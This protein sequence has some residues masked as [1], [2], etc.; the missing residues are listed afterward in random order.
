M[1]PKSRQDFTVAIICALS[2]EADAVEA[3]FD[4]TYDRLGKYYGK[5]QGDANA[6]IN[7][8]I[9]NHDVVLCYTSGIGKGSAASVA[10]SLQVSYTGIEL[11]LV[12]G[13][14]GGTSS[15]S[16]HQEIFLGDAIISDSV[17]VYDFGRQYPGGF[18]RKSG[19]KDTLGRPN[20][21][22]R[23]LLNG[24][25]TN[26]AL[27]EL[28]SQMQGYLE[29][30]QQKGTRWRHPQIDD[31]LFKASYLHKHY[32]RASDIQCGCSES[33]IP[34]EIC[35]SA[36]EESC[37]DLGCDKGQIIRCREFGEATKASI[38]IGILASA[39]IVMKSGQHRDAIVRKEKIIGFEMEGAGVWDNISCIIIKG[40]CD[41]ADSHKN[42]LWQDY[43]AATG[44]SAAKAFLEFWPRN[45]E[46]T[47]KTAHFM[48]PF[49]RNPRFVGR[50]DEIDRLEELIS[51]PGRLKKIA[52]TGLGGVGKTQVALELAYRM[53]AR[54]DECSIFWIPCTSYEAVEQACMAIAQMVGIQSVKPAEV[55]EHLKTYFSQRDGKWLLIFDNADDMEM[56]MKGS[57]TSSALKDFLPYGSHGHIVFTT[58][59]QK[60]AVRLAS[61]DVIHVREL[62]EETG[63]EFL[64]KLLMQKSLLHDSSYAVNTLLQQLT[65]LPLALTQAAAY[66]NENGI[67]LSDYLLLLQ[68]QEAE[69]VELLNEDFDDD[70][71]YKESQNPVAKTWLISFHQIRKLDELAS[72]YLS[73]MACV[74]P[75]NIP[76][77]FLPWPGSRKKMTEALGL[78]KAYSFI[79]I[80]PGNGSITLHRL[81]H[82]ATRNWMRKEEQFSRY[83]RQAAA[84]LNEIFTSNNYTNRQLRREYLPHALVLLGESQFKKQQDTYVSLIQLVG[85]F[86]ASDGRY[87]EAE[88]LL[89]QVMGTQKQVL[90][91]EHPATLASIVNLASI[92]LMQGRWKEAEELLL[93]TIKT[94][95]RVLG[96]EHPDTLTGMTNLASICLGQGRLKEAEELQMHIITNQKQILGPEHP[97]TLASMDNLASIYSKQGRWNEA[98]ELQTEIITTQKQILGPE[99]PGT[100]EAIHSLAFTWKSLGNIQPALALMDKCVELRNK[101]LGSDHPDSISSYNALKNWEAEVNSSSAKQAQQNPPVIPMHTQSSHSFDLDPETVK[102]ARWQ[103]L[104]NFFRRPWFH[105]Y[106]S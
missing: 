88:N 64:G 17:I 80:Q 5:Q 62:D 32:A 82:L 38:H 60:L 94:Q 7:G 19:V 95:K 44:A 83:I 37:N 23:T 76:E 51:T 39:D 43:A 45:Q 87:N 4:E 93:Q 97:T 71:R 92:Y 86:L 26:N 61:S 105:S 58:R 13:I 27:S 73:L 10:S 65:F 49:A 6:Y 46:D 24:L 102:G 34:E 56:W 68:E 2:L 15:Q 40:V 53:Q 99:H 12:V 35:E 100:L 28:Q 84:R 25:R 104:K 29:T 41:Y 9:G 98:E 14:C 18:Q 90:G 81:V 31:I 66:I 52:I 16:D 54:E 20:R 67:N 101:V 11:A 1:R 55:K 59:N 70:G 3:L 79:T 57:K 33:D 85:I 42:K 30:L 91:P 22:I 69:V 78:L 74:H 75:R 89:S 8:R 21:E 106:T 63:V 36:L 103:A 48:I 47:R 50:Q 96:P 72:G 77:S